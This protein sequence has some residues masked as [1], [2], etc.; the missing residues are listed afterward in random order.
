M[1]QKNVRIGV[2]GL[3]T[4]LAILFGLQSQVF[5]KDNQSNRD[6]DK[7]K[8]VFVTPSGFDKVVL[9]MGNGIFDPNLDSPRPG[10]VGCTGLFCDGAFFQ[11]EIMNR[12]DAE[13]AAIEADAK[14]YFKN[15]FGVDVDNPAMANR[16][17]F[18][19]F[20]V[21]PDFQYR[22]HALS[23]E[24]VTSDGWIIR[25][26]G[27]RMEVI[28][29]EGI[30]LEGEFAGVHVPMGTGAFF[31]H[32]NIL[33]TDKHGNANGELIIHYESS[34]PAHPLPNGDFSF[35]CNMF[36]DDWGQGIGMGTMNFIPQ[37][38]GRVRGNVRNFLTFGPSSTLMEYP[39]KPAFDEKP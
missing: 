27:F 35:K 18:K 39:A 15:H 34:T 37:D 5:A 31:G 11:H 10:V 24:Q 2:I 25:D 9:Y 3:L 28:D 30:T 12:S 19:M 17:S 29:P 22:V 21:N 6:K 32:Y 26:G 38:D 23:G 1:F 14:E 36:H 13:I 4:L 33:K 20:M 8:N 16:V 7:G